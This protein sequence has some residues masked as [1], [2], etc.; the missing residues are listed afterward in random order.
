LGLVYHAHAASAD[1]ADQAVFAQRLEGLRQVRSQWFVG[2]SEGADE[3]ETVEVFGQ[4]VG[5][6]GVVGEERFAI[7]WAARLKID[8][9]FVEQVDK[10]AIFGCVLFIEL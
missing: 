1:L 7:D 2:G 3:L 5:E 4:L 8:E 6:V 10:A 9:A